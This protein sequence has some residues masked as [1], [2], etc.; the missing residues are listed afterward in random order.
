MFYLTT[1]HELA[2]TTVEY[3]VLV[4]VVFAGFVAAVHGLEAFLGRDTAE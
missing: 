2:M 1:I 4:L 3:C